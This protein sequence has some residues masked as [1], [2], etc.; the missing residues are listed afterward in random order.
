MRETY[1]TQ[2]RGDNFFFP[3]RRPALFQRVGVK[4]T[5]IFCV[6]FKKRVK[7]FLNSLRLVYSFALIL[8]DKSRWNVLIF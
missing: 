8:I 4:I 7:S 3:P 5:R 2:F 6:G 1:N